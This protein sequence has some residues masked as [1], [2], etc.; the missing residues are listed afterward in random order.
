M[1][2]FLVLSME[3]MAAPAISGVYPTYQTAS[4]L[5]IVPVFP[6]CGRPSAVRARCPVPF[7]T[8]LASSLFMPSATSSLITRWQLPL[9]MSSSLPFRS[10]TFSRIIGSQWMPRAAKVAYASAIDSGL[11]S[12]EPRVNAGDVLVD[13]RPARALACRA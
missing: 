8:T 13:S 7:V 11:T 5:L 4:L 2:G 12:T 10:V 1:K 9:A 6:A 3:I